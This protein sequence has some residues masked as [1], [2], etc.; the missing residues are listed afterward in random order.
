ML[1]TKTFYLVIV[2]SFCNKCDENCQ[3]KKP[4][5]H[6]YTFS[7]SMNTYFLTFKIFLLN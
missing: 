7:I 5:Q 1:I 6:N 2:F 3:E 4:Q